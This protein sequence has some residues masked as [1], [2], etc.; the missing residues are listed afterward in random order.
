MQP[1]EFLAILK[2]L[3]ADTALTATHIAALLE[4]LSPVLKKPATVDLDTLPASKLID[5]TMLAD[6]LGESVSSLQKWRV[7]GNGPKFVK[8]PKSVRYRVGD[9]RDWI[10]H[11][12]V[13]ST[14]EATTRLSRFGDMWDG[15]DDPVPTIIV[16]N[17]HT[18]F[19]RSLEAVEEPSG[20]TWLA[21]ARERPATFADALANPLAGQFAHLLEADCDTAIRLADEYPELLD[22]FRPEEWFFDRAFP[23]LPG[24][25]LTRLL[26]AFRFF[27]DSGLNLNATTRYRLGDQTITASVPHLLTA[28]TTNGPDDSNSFTA[29]M[30]ELLQAGMD[31]DMPD[32][33]GRSALQVARDLGFTLYPKC[34]NA[35][36]LRRK[37]SSE[38]LT[39][40]DEIEEDGG[41]L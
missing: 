3:P 29:F 37:L 10:S 27:V 39:D 15:F 36:R 6:W 11:N 31:V 14:S 1:S 12:T 33:D 28:V 34:V 5:E 23:Q 16:N 9:V 40:D 30:I 21:A 38:L 8:N 13:Q 26:P 20:Y 22:G 24:S 2:S 35:H 41:K 18:G 25:E 17:V 4:T 7:S 32:E 19:F